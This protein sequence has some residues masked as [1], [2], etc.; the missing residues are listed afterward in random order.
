MFLN[1]FVCYARVYTSAPIVK[2]GFRLW[3]F[4]QKA[5]SMDSLNEVTPCVV[6]LEGCRGEARGA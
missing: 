4:I 3:D 2:K 6:E 1:T 5:E